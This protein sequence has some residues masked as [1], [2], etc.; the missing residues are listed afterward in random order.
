VPQGQANDRER[1]AYVQLAEVRA[2]A[3][4]SLNNLPYGFT[5]ESETTNLISALLRIIDITK[6]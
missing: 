2:I 5:G 4:Q 3:E 1:S 6:S